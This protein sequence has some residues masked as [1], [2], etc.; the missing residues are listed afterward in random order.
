MPKCAVSHELL[1]SPGQHGLD[2]GQRRPLLRGG[3]DEY[4][5]PREPGPHVGDRSGQ[6]HARRQPTG[7]ARLLQPRPQRARTQQVERLIPIPVPA[8]RGSVLQPR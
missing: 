8:D 5:R 3:Q 2:E 7:R 4:G 6:A 1:I